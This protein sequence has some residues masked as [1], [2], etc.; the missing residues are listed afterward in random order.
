L[1]EKERGVR[2]DKER[3]EGVARRYCERA[4]QGEGGRG[5]R[6]GVWGIKREGVR[7]EI[8]RGEVVREI[9]CVR[10]RGGGRERGGEINI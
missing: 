9:L 10:E 4:I 6:G 8:E 3:V 2:R 5:K 7:G 1:T